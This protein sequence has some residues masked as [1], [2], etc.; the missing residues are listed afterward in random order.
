MVAEEATQFFRQINQSCDN[1]ID[2][3]KSVPTKKYL[4]E[5]GKVR[6]KSGAVPQL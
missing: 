6:C 5:M 1:L 4:E 2:V 3:Q